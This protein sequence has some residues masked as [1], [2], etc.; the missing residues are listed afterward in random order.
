MQKEKAKVESE[1]LIEKFALRVSIQGCMVQ[2]VVAR[3]V[4]SVD[5]NPPT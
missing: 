1:K 3:V 2:S 4:L 5:S